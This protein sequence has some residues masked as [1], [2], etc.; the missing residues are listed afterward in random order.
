[1]ARRRPSGKLDAGVVATLL[2]AELRMLL[3]DRRTV[4]VSIVLPVLVM[5]LLLFASRWM[6]QR[7]QAK[8]EITQFRYA[9]AG[10]E[11]G[12]AQHLIAATRERLAKETS[13]PALRLEAV[14][15]GDPAAALE[16]GN[17]DFYVKA[18]TYAE[19][20]KQARDRKA[21]AS[22]PSAE[23]AAAHGASPHLAPDVPVLELV[24]RGD[25][26]R[27]SSGMEKLRAALEETRRKQRYG[28]LQQRGFPVPPDQAGAVETT[29][30]ASAAQVTGLKVG[31]LVTLFF[32]LFILSGGAVVATDTLAGEKE[33]GTLE[34][35]LTTAA[36]RGEIIAAKHLAIFTVAVGI[37]VIQTLNFLAYVVF[38]LIPLPSDFVLN[39]S[40]GTA[41]LL[42]VLL[43]PVA[44]LVSSVLL[45]VSGIA[46]TYKEAQL[47]F[48]PVF[49]LGLAPAAAPFLPG[50]PLRSAIVLVPVS[51]VAVAIKEIMV[52]TFDWPMLAVA[53]G[54]TL[55]A[56]VWTGRLAA[57]TLSTERLILAG[58][59]ETGVAPG[60]QQYSRHVLRAF[61]VM[62]ALLFIIDSNVEGKVDL[63]VELLLNLVVIFLGGA[64]FLLRRYRLD[65][66]EALALRPVRAPVWLAVLVGAPAGLVTGLGVFR[67]ASLV[68]PVSPRMIEAFSQALLPQQI[69]FWQLVV[70]AAVL[71]GICEETAFRG[72]LLYGLHRRLHPVALVA[73]V[74]VAF[75]L[76]HV[77]LFRIA[78]TAYLGMLLAAVTLLTGSIFPAMVWH[79]LNNGVALAMARGDI[80]LEAAGA[81][82]YAAAVALL[83][84]AFWVLWRSRTPYPGLRR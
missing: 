56:A 78:P 45:L 31:R 44:A 15:T 79:A 74:G 70:F 84:V 81:W 32:L 22:P 75:G 20:E 26:D 83:V 37:T 73:V 57:R 23:P 19:A 14:E 52:G 28:L 40:A 43:L 18:M 11:A 1:M 5:P 61:A 12:L 51:N 63:R 24:F 68:F 2:R 69:P 42:L 16:K 25:R 53:F 33:R 48:F 30:V 17:L 64:A 67:L 27:S 39:V 47:Y 7:R 71:P 65:P 6:E 21:E 3:R 60:P 82:I 59:E 38:R 55:A 76:F 72:M 54:T 41:V 4:M 50:L 8:L 13:G 10:P 80:T 49:L 77:A 58:A 62:W 29:D 34:T 46:K 36:G 9:V 66:H 35:L